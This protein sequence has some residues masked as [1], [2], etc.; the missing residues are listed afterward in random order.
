M[1]LYELPIAA[2]ISALLII[3]LKPVLQRYACPPQ[4]R[5]SHQVPTPQGGGIA[6]I[7]AWSLILSTLLATTPLEWS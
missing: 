3:I 1:N 7:G 5:S 4:A 6:V 2:L